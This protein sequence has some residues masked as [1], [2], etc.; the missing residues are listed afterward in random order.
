MAI[1]LL[2]VSVTLPG[3]GPMGTVVTF[4]ESRRIARD[5]YAIGTQNASA[6][7][8]I[9][10]VIRIEHYSD[11]PSDGCSDGPNASGRKRRRPTT[12]S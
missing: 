1:R 7:I 11:E 10:P 2:G 8:I 9:L 5:A 4:P 12:R 6:T 3:G